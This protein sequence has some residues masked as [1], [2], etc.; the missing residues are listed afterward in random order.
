MRLQETSGRLFHNA[1][2]DLLLIINGGRGVKRLNNLSV[3]FVA[4]IL[5]CSSIVSISIVWN[6]EAASD[7]AKIYVDPPVVA[8]SV[9]SEFTVNVNITSLVSDLQLYGFEIKL[10]WGNTVLEYVSRSIRVPKNTYS[11]GVLWSPVISPP[12]KDELDPVAG[13]YWLLCQSYGDAPSFNESGVAVKLTFKVLSPGGEC[14]I[15]FLS[16]VLSDKA[17]Q[18]IPHTA[19]DGYVSLPGKGNVPVCAPFTHSPAKPVA[20]RT[21]VTFDT[22]DSYDP[23][24][25][26]IASYIWW[27]GDNR[28]ISPP[29]ETSHPY[30]NNLNVTYTVSETDAIWMRVHFSNMTMDQNDNNVYALAV[31]GSYLYAGLYTSPGKIVKINSTFNQVGTVTFDTGENKITS[32]AVSG[33]YLYAGLDT[34]PGKVVKI[35]LS[36]FTKV[37]TLTLNTGENNVMSLAIYGDYLFAGLNTAP[38]NV[39]KIDITGGTTFSRV[40]TLKLASGEN[41]VRALAVSGSYLYA[42][43]RTSPGKVV[44][45]DPATLTKVGTTLT[46]STGEN[47]IVSLAASGSYLYAGLELSPGRVVKIDQTPSRI[48]A[49]TLST[50]ENNVLSLAVSGNYLFAG[51]NTAP[52]NVT[53]I[54]ITGGTTFSKVGTLK[55]SIGENNVRSVVAN[56]TYLYAGLNTLPG[57]VVKIDLGTFL[58]V[59]T[60]FLG[61]QI[62]VYDKDWNLIRIYYDNALD[63]WTSWIKGNRIYIVFTSDASIT[64]WGFKADVYQCYLKTTSLT[65][66]FTCYEKGLYPYGPYPFTVK[67]SVIDVEGS[68]SKTQSLY[69]EVLHPRPVAQFTTSPQWPHF[70]ITSVLFDAS[71]SFDPDGV[72]IQWYAWDFGDGA[73]QNLTTPTTTHLY[74]YNDTFL[75]GL[76]VCD[77]EN[78]LAYTGLNVFVVHAD[79]N[80]DKKINVPD[81]Y[82]LASAFGSIPDDPNWNPDADTN[83]DGVINDDDLIILSTYYGKTLP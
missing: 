3:I 61:D 19:Y 42:G 77:A 21:T 43:L 70:N 29:A 20:N 35:D 56:S 74:A 50:G 5:I 83:K 14:D 57:K 72:G 37:S 12:P 76:T 71:E 22:S 80:N 39:T 16:T 27:F 52:G 18:P 23:D 81:L 26:G 82:E 63:V 30:S 40:G 44:K 17:G 45:I 73:T 53:K 7:R 64:Y 25:G 41:Y 8:G 62:K 69:L 38:G 78:L 49:I 51:L 68:Q 11:D 33:S 59:S 47:Y 79:V 36:A 15:Y 66:V 9:G 55:L 31:S 4:L 24:G 65:H 46:L 1:F 60:I 6:A 54:D 75:V 13:T 2:K 34:T 32:L 67:L 48:G 58:K 28:S 10:A